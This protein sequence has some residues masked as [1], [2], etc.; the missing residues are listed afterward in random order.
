MV[1]KMKEWWKNFAGRKCP[2]IISSRPTKLE[3]DET[4]EVTLPKEVGNRHHSPRQ[5]Q[6]GIRVPRCPLQC[7]TRLKSRRREQR[8][9]GTSGACVLDFNS[10]QNLRKQGSRF[11]VESTRK[12]E[13]YIQSWYPH[14]PFQKGNVTLLKSGISCEVRL[15]QARTCAFPPQ[16]GGKTGA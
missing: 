6:A 2:E 8:E 16:Q 13:E 4:N 5:G 10:L 11:D 9:M 15:A 3:K 7:S 1:L 14:A 12:P